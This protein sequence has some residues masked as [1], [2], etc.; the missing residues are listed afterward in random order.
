MKV[1]INGIPMP[2][3]VHVTIPPDIWAFVEGCWKRDPKSR[4]K[5]ADIISDLKEIEAHLLQKIG[6]AH[7]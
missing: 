4:L 2:Q 7:V 6:R 3:D 1:E 5:L